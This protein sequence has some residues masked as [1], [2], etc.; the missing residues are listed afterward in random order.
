MALSANL[1]PIYPQEEGP[2]SELGLLASA[3]VFVGSMVG[4]SSGY[5]RALV[6]GDQFLGL[7]F[8]HHPSTVNFESSASSG[9]AA[10]H[11][12]TKGK[13]QLT[14]TGVTSAA[15]IGKRV[16]ASADNTF[17]LSSNDG[18]Y[19]P[20]G[21]VWRYVSTG[22]AIVKYSTLESHKRTVQQYG[23][24]ANVAGSGVPLSATTNVTAHM[25]HVDD[26]GVALTAGYS[27]AGGKA[28]MLFN[29]AST[30]DLSVFGFEGQCKV[31]GNQGSVTGN[32]AGVWGYLEMISGGTVNVAAGVMAA[33]DIPSGATN[34][35]I[36]SCLQTGS[37][38]LAGT[39]TGPTCAIYSRNSAATA[40]DYWLVLDA[41]SD[42]VGSVQT[43]GTALYLKVKIGTKDYTIK[44]DC[45]S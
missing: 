5:A 10:C 3:E 21:E 6:S 32:L 13:V 30:G 45:A 2:I 37:G 29:T 25:V 15:D 22:V 42:F 14:V 20:I 24:K 39:T 4:E 34:S 28:R 44:C 26:G 35:G 23:I 19:T 38:S 40:F 7:S 36:A 17:T 12:K 16:F 8:E 18:T 41:S 9:L 33:I 31:G 27:Y 11:F 43:G 1:N